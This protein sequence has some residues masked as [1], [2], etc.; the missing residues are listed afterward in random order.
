MI[1]HGN[2]IEVLK[3]FSDNHF[4][5]VVTDPPYGISFMNK[6]WDYDVPNVEL[7]AEVL[8]VLKPGGHM[9][10]ACGTRTQH[11]MAVNIEDAGFEIRDI[12]S[13][14]YGSGFPKSLS[15]DKAIDKQAGEKGTRGDFISK[16]HA[17][18]RKPGNERM[19]EGYQRPWRDDPDTE[20]RNARI[21]IPS[22]EA[23]KQW[24]GFG[25]ALK[26]ACE[27]WT[28]ARKPL[29]EKTVAENV[30]K[31]G[32]GGINIDGCRI[33]TDEVITNHSR[34]A[35][36]AISKGKYGDSEAQETHQTNGQQLGRFPANLVFSCDCEGLHEEGCPVGELDRQ[37][38]VLTSGNRTGHRNFPK[39]K[40][41]FGSFELKDELPSMGD[42]GTASRFFYVA[43]ASK[44][45]RNRGLEGMEKKY[46]GENLGQLGGL[47][48]SGNPR[49]YYS[50]NAH[51]TVKPVTLMRYLCRLITPP[52]GIILDP[53]NGSGSTGV[54]AAL[55]WF[56]YVGIE[57]DETHVE[58]SQKRKPPPDLF[59]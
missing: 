20:D 1:I 39:T 48:G 15:I 42:T 2:N 16:D 23:A 55:E 50:E 7:W 28:L 46:K 49:N 37:S 35:E 11:R 59:T 43:K 10:C 19:H 14:W 30:L 12:V 29:S 24:T 53:F 32:T 45:E 3:T 21:Y 5:G 27:L 13:W 51:P 9:L 22:T 17:I 26:P 44:T 57:Q 4:D 56:E 34:G 18:K 36:A 47:T 8:R 54:A 31:Y 38:G 41:S 58:V 6:K 33:S 52:K 25:T 40:N